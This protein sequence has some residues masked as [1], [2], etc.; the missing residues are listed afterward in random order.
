[1]VQ[2]LFTFGLPECVSGRDG[3][4]SLGSTHDREPP[5]GDDEDDHR[6]EA[7]DDSTHRATSE[8]ACPFLHG[9]LPEWA[10]AMPS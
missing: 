8:S 1:M 10:K 9:E 7:K 2:R 3:G 5:E 4:A 6:D